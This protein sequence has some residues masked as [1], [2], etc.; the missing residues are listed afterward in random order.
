MKLCNG[1][2]FMG[3][4]MVVDWAVL[5]LPKEGNSTVILK[6]KDEPEERAHSTTSLPMEQESSRVETRSA[7]LQ[8]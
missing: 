1:K 3:R 4:K 2:D 8:L 5:R 6:T 7:R